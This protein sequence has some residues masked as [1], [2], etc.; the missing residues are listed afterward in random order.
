MRLRLSM[1]AAAALVVVGAALAAGTQTTHAV[2][3]PIGSLRPPQTIYVPEDYGHQFNA[4]PGDTVILVMRPDDGHEARCADAG[5]RIES[6]A[7]T[8]IT[9]CVGVDF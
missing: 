7:H 3:T 9:A 6:N 1:I 2:D 5:G 8:W 4:E